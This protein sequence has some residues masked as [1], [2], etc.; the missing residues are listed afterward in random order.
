M[1]W[2][3]GASSRGGGDPSGQRAVPTPSRSIEF[4]DFSADTLRDAKI[5]SSAPELVGRRLRCCCR[6]ERARCL[7]PDV[8]EE[9]IRLTAVQA[10]D[11][12]AGM[13]VPTPLRR[14][15]SKTT[16]QGLRGTSQEVTKRRTRRRTRLEEND[17]AN[18]WV[19][20]RGKRMTPESSPSRKW[21]RRPRSW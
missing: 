20:P 19:H 6:L 21:C 11:S 12:D 9:A 8:L 18:R 2:K 14:L 1:I 13:R 15:T 5:W 17:A 10:V 7:Q 3:A 4:V 16:V